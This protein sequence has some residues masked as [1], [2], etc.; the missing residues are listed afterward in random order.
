MR[1]LA[2]TACILPGTPDRLAPLYRLFAQARARNFSPL[3]PM[4]A[5]S[6]ETSQIL[7]A[8]TTPS[9]EASRD[10]LDGLR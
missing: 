10:S 4:L 2:V 6:D 7:A 3:R 1:R 9:A 8:L 5:A